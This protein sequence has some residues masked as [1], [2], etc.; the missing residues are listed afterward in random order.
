MDYWAALGFIPFIS[1]KFVCFGLFFLSGA[2]AAAAAHNPPKDSKTK[3]HFHSIHSAIAAG[4]LSSFLLIKFKEKKKW[5]A[6]S[7][8]N[9]QF[10]F[11]F[12]KS[13]GV[14]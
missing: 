5:P 11:I 8:I 10:D 2:M 1:V 13:N 4:L 9:S 7:I 3:L 14:D 6:S 12:T